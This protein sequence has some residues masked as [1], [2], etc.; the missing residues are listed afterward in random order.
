MDRVPEGVRQ[1]LADHWML[2]TVL[3]INDFHNKNWLIEKNTVL[4]IDVAYRSLAFRKGKESL[5]LAEQEMPFDWMQAVP[6]Y[7]FE[8]MV[9]WASPEMI[10]FLKTIDNRSIQRIADMSY[11]PLTQENMDGMT[12]RARRL[13]SYRNK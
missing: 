5:K 7:A 9:N 8:T 10:A 2:Y 1:Q 12:G 6:D 4:A 13:L 11:Y 3:G